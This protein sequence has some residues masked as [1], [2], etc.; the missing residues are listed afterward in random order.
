M[1]H[2]PFHI[3][4]P[5]IEPVP[6]LISVPHSSVFFPEN[7]IDQYRIEVLEHKDDTDFFVDR[8][9]D[10]APSLGITMI[11]ATIN[12]WVIDLNRNQENNHLYNDGRII[13]SL[14]PETDFNGQPLYK[15]DHGYPASQEIQQRIKHYYFPYHQ[16]VAAILTNFKSTYGKALL[17]DA[18]SIKRNVPKIQKEPF[19]DFIIG[20]NDGQ[21]IH[22]ALTN[23]V[24]KSLSTENY[25]VSIN[26]P[27]KGGHI[28]RSFG[29]PQQ[30]IHAIQ[31]EMSK[32]CYLSDDER[33]YHNE[34]A[35]KIQILLKSTFQ[36]LIPK[37][38][39]V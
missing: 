6:I 11:V 1:L 32:D 17:W 22:P 13:T 16:K 7:I 31:L 4:Q 23:S 14:V 2:P 27:F 26:D 24:V 12:R 8:L 21:S 18:H 30:N 39:T 25:S 36:K 38:D 33:Q 3:I 29:N 5:K 37:L 19:T 35:G 10:F 20:T 9:Y 34:K 15:A 28:T